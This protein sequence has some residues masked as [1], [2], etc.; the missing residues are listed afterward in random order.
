MV[1]YFTAKTTTTTNNELSDFT[2]DNEDDD[3]TNTHIIY[4]GKDKFEN[5]PLIKHSNPKNIWFHVDNHSSAHLYLQLTKEQIINWKSFDLFKIEE[6]L[7]IQLCQLTKANSIKG[8]K[9]NNITIIYTPVENLYTDGSM[10][11]GTVTFKNN[12]NVKRMNIIKRDNSIINK[13]NKTKIEKST[14]EFL[15][16]QDQLIRDINN[17]RKKQ[18]KETKS[19]EKQ[20][21]ELKLKNNDP[22]GDLFTK[23]NLENSSNDRRKENWDEDDFCPKGQISKLNTKEQ[24]KTNKNSTEL[25]K[26]KDPELTKIIINQLSI[27]ITTITLENIDSYFKQIHFILNKQ[28]KNPII[29]SNYF[30]KLI[31][32]IKV[33]DLKSTSLTPVELLITKELNHLAIDLKY[34]DLFFLHFD[35]LQQHIN[36]IDFVNKFKF[37]LILSF[38]LVV[39]YQ[40]NLNFDQ[41]KIYLQLKSIAL[42][43]LIKTKKY[44]SNFNWNLLLD[45]ILN[46][47]FF[48]FLGKL[49]TL[50][51]IKAFDLSIEPVN[52][53]YQNILKMSFKELLN[54][55]GFENLIPEKLLPNLLQIKP[56]D[57]DQSIALILSEILIPGSQGLNHVNNLQTSLPEANAKGALLKASFINIEQ[58]N[59]ININWYEV[60]NH[61]HQNLFES[62]Q[63]NIQPSVASVIQFL[64][65]L[66]FKQEPLDIFLNYDWWFDKT[67]LYILQTSDGSQGGYDVSK[68]QNLALCFEDDKLKQPSPPTQQQQQIRRNILKFINI[69]KLELQ[70]INKIQL[71]EHQQLSEQ[72]RKLNTFSNQIFE[73]DYRTFPEYVLAAALSMVE[74]TQFINDLID[75]LF[76]IIMDNES[77]SLPKILNLLQ[78]IGIAVTKLIEYLRNRNSF[79]ATHKVMGV[80]TKNNLVQDLF[81]IVWSTDSKLALKL[82]IESSFHDYDYK[83][84]LDLKLKDSQLIYQ[85]L[86]EVLNERA[87]KDYETSQ[88]HQQQQQQQQPQTLPPPVTLPILKISTTYHLLEILKS[89]NGLVDLEKLKNLQI[90]LLTTY[91]RLINFG[92][93]SDEAI[94]INES[95]SSFFPP[96]V[97]L[98]MKD[99]YSKMYSKAVD[100]PEIVDI[101]VKMKTSNDPH[102]QD[103]FACMIHS[104][105]DEYKFFAEYPLAA[106]ASTSLL[107]GALLENDLIHGTTLTVA[108]NFIWESC[109]QPSESKLFKFA[110]QSLYNF[111]SKL[112][113][114]PIYCKHLLECRSLSTHSKMY[115]IVKDAANGIPCGN[116]GTTQVSTPDI[117]HKYQ[118]INY[119][120]HTIGSIKQEQPDEEV[121]D[122]LLFLV[123]N[124]TSE[125]LRLSEF[126]ENLQ[127]KFYSWFAD[128]LVADRAKQE[129]NNHTLYVE[130][131]KSISDPVFT[132]YV[133]NTTIRE[134]IESIKMSNDN[135]RH[136]L[137][138]LG[139]WLGKLTLANNQPLK[140][141]LI[142]MKF[143]LVEAYDF[144][145]LP[146]ILPFVCKILTQAQYS[147][148]FKP[149][150]PWVIGI[151]EVLV[152]LYHHADLKL[153]LK[154]EIEVLFNSLELKM[155][156]LKQSQLIRN[157]NPDPTVLAIRFGLLPQPGNNITNEFSRLNL[158]A[159]QQPIGNELPPFQQGLEKQ[160]QQSHQQQQQQQQQPILQQPQSN[161]IQLQQQQPQAQPQAQQPQPQPPQA[162]PGLD[163][164]FSTLA[165][166]SIFTQHANLRRAFQASLSRAVRE[167]AIPIMNRVSEAVLITTEFLIKKDF[168]TERDVE[169]IRKSYHKLT[170]QLSHSMVLCSGKKLLAETIEATMLQ[171]LGNNPNEI[172]MMELNN[173]IQANVGLCVDIVDK[174]ASANILD[175]IEERMKPY[176]LKREQF[177]SDETFIEE[178]TPEYALR[179][180]EPLGL[181]PRGLSAQQLKIY[182]QF[183]ELRGDQLGQR[184]GPP[185]GVLLQ[186]QPQQSQLQAQPSLAQQQ[187]L[188]T[189]LQQTQHNQLTQDFPLQHQASTT[190]IQEDVI[191]SEH[192][193]TAITQYCE[194]AIQMV[195]E[196]SENKLSDLPPNHPIMTTLTQALAIAQS[197]ASKYPDLLLKS[198]QYAVNCLF[199]QIHDNPMTNEIYVVMLDKLCDY[200]PSTAKDVTWWLVHSS[201]Q[202]KFNI[203]VILSLLKVQLI[204]PIKLD[205]SLGKLIKENFNPSVVKFSAN[206]LYNVFNSD[207]ITRPIALRSEF[208]NTLDALYEFKNLEIPVNSSEEET[209]ARNEVTKLFDAL[210]DS[211]TLTSLLS[212][213]LFTQLGYIFAE[214]VRLLTHGSEDTK[215]AQDK[216]VSELIDSGI[217]NNPEYFR[218]FWKA[219]IDISTILFTT[220]HEYRS[221]TQHEAYLSVDALAILAIKI[222]LVIDSEEQAL[223]YLR[224]IISVISLNLINEHE[225]NKTTWNERAYFRFYSSLLSAWNDSSI[226]D[227]DATKSLDVEFYEFMGQIFNSLQPLV[228]PGFTFAW[229]SLISHRLFLPKILELPDKVGFG[230]AVKLLSSLLKFQQTYQ[231][232]DNNPDVLNVVFKAIN[233][234]FIGLLHD[235]P[236]FLAECHYQLITAIPRSYIQLK[237]IVLS[238]TPQNIVVP[239]PFTQGL[240]VERLPEINDAPLIYYKPIEDLSKYNLKKP[241]EN[242]LRIPA[243]GLM[244][245]IYNGLKLTNSKKTDE[246]GYSEVINFNPKLINALVLNVGMNA[247]ADRLPNNRGFNTKTS[248]VALLVDLMNHGTN[249]FKYIMINSI[250][251]QLRYPNSHTHWFIGIMLHFFS[252][253]SIWSNGNGNSNSTTKLI[254]QEI[255]TRV[256][257]ERRIVNKPHP[258]GL[259][260]SFTELVKNE[261]YGFFELSFVKNSIDEIKVIFETLSKNLK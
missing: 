120:E 188:P 50:S 90:L 19:L 217:L 130:L 88:Q 239:D 240:K 66:D 244:K 186:P 21:S 82:L 110:V 221:R 54:E 2:L 64:S 138:N 233:R 224:K 242:F 32:I 115:Q 43:D 253:N 196:V 207:D 85:T 8:N 258:W 254:V 71:Q 243:P 114:Y 182:E 257:L 25:Y 176:I 31:N 38:I 228:F 252:S 122:K 42:L 223:Q 215:I 86:L 151:L 45:Y 47:P 214:W 222:I 165:G 148:V 119:V 40:N 183:G 84:E 208:A 14:E 49:L 238:A 202:R 146:L 72:D 131:V 12:K 102:Q 139:S 6:N 58:S 261:S 229:I 189:Q 219:G 199:T 149:P 75:T 145:S 23:E 60:F 18:E 193:F 140:R 91:P 187:Q 69:G 171:L 76:N 155:D 212:N 190:M 107:F 87:Q 259:T 24:S 216:F 10:D 62:N 234:I 35:K 3:N 96:D 177:K 116:S 255:I 7:L 236:E 26:I 37:D 201:D 184:V 260:I 28:D 22:Y 53:F 4:M 163:T 169:K 36:I 80:A 27:L 93:G 94:L 211:E 30:E 13:L 172:P 29:L 92:N 9:L 250:A 46:K 204:Q 73:H 232:K 192:L 210:N 159:S 89:S 78:E 162:E 11:T 179:L 95:K 106:L 127:E 198:A 170:Q 51:S 117:G 203:P 178:V 225:D 220:E 141:N 1:Y 44:P 105:L 100:I 157:H 129:P 173:A 137:K 135:K 133:M 213:E 15:K 97:E 147:K 218:S 168:A 98:E 112:H 152:E 41:V 101:L 175:L 123:N 103:V 81:Q 235:Y 241:I 231:L 161:T 167:C 136:N 59:K 248:Q 61:V 111:K 144:K 70:V 63:R 113:E 128:Y 16:E 104:L 39:K 195:S 132:E 108:L 20:Y 174:I 245:N 125:N 124:M 158:V 164:S 77:T 153:Q 121:R 156:D 5:D 68:S 154:F 79:E 52:K 227:E 247:V 134:V 143:L 118:S 57:I 181:N 160:F 180:P 226:L 230:I 209:E 33:S 48:P 166:N 246:F 249:E 205:A 55:V 56:E 200:S 256:L 83:K 191:T 237:N 206:L 142:A 251:N 74:K 150:N 109:N 99:Y 67:L 194:K 65:S 34:C 126:Q 17:F 185:Q 197:N